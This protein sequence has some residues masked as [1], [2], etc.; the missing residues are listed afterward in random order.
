MDHYSPVNPNRQSHI[1]GAL[2][3]ER[4]RQVHGVQ[5][6]AGGAQRAAQRVHLAAADAYPVSACFGFGKHLLV[7]QPNHIRHLWLS[8]QSQMGCVVSAGNEAGPSPLLAWGTGRAK[9]SCR[10]RQPFACVLLSGLRNAPALASPRALWLLCSI[11]R[12]V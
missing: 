6:L 5:A 7:Y 2:S 10:W 9:A 1:A 4:G 11:M 12:A 3:V 8:V